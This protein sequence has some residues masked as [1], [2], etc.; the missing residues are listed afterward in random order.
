MYFN[1]NTAIA[2]LASCIIVISADLIAASL[3]KGRLLFTT[4]NFPEI[5]HFVQQKM[6]WGKWK[7]H[8]GTIIGL[9]FTLIASY[10]LCKH[11]FIIKNESGQHKQKPRE[12]FQYL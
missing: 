3:N 2:L 4:K 5:T 12:T 7:P 8:A 10:F 6:N 9:L 11:L 1:K